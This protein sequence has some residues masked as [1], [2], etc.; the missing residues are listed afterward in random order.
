MV[1]KALNLVFS[2]RFVFLGLAILMS[3]LGVVTGPKL[4]LQLSISK[5]LPEDRQSVVEMN[6]VAS[7]VGGVGFLVMIIGPTEAP[8]QY[9]PQLAEKMQ[10]SEHVSYS[11]YNTEKHLLKDK[12]LYLL[13]K[14]DFK[15]L[16]RSVRDLF[17]NANIGLGLTS[18]EE[19]EKRAKDF[20]A[21]IDDK[22]QSKPFF[23]SKDGRYAMV[24]VKPKF[25]SEDLDR[26]K[27]LVNHANSVAHEVLKGKV[28]YH[29]A[30]R[31]ADKVRDTRQIQNDIA[32]T[33][34][35]SLVGLSI[36]L[37]WGLGSF[38]ATLVTLGGVLVSLGWTMGIAKYAVGQI[39]I[40]TGFLLAIL[41]G[42]GVEYGIH[43]IRR[44]EQE[45][46]SG[47]DHLTSL[48]KTYFQMG[49]ALFSAAI[50]S[51]CAF[52]ILSLS[53]FRGFSE[54]GIIAGLGVLGIYFSYILCFPALG[55]MLR[56]KP[57][58]GQSRKIFGVY[59]F[60]KKWAKPILIVSCILFFCAPLAEFEYDF[61]RMHRL[62]KKSKEM[63]D[64]SDELFGKSLTPA[65]LLASDRQQA[66]QLR[67]WLIKEEQKE[68]IQNAVSIENVTPSDMKSRYRQIK[69]LNKRIDDISDE[70][71]KEK[72]DLSAKEVRKWLQEKPYKLSDLP[73]PF[74]STFGVSEKI[75]YT[76]PVENLNQA[77]PLRRFTGKLKEARQEFPGTQ[78]G[79]DATV[80]VEIIEHIID[81]G[82]IVLLL[83]L[84]GAFFVF[85]LDF[86][87][88]TGALVLELQ[89][90]AGI[91]LLC[92]LMAIFG[93]RFSILNVAM[94]PA[95]LAAGVDMGVHVRH[96]E[97]EGYSPLQ[98]AKYVAQAVQLSML[99]TMMGF[100][101]VLFA[102]AGILRGIALIS[103]LGQIS[104][105]LIC[106]VIVP[107]L[108][109]TFGQKISHFFFKKNRKTKV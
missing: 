59:P 23:L 62:S 74:P 48:K 4:P 89:L 101:A 20:F 64:L 88:V 18:K 97:L 86:K 35:I 63:N 82:K 34:L 77:D 93:E 14:S 84:T 70:K 10:T 46:I 2:H 27:R 29:L 100:G 25:N 85:W 66:N 60:S 1:R 40:L 6:N 99:T 71:I 37:L 90:I 98:A 52:L 39:N 65:A 57:R 33:G 5:L 102:E 12:A 76:Y 80:F 36:I 24:L 108:K 42:L 26:S 49:R 9:L 44:Y 19:K 56:G 95:V 50:T 79:S 43:L 107:V 92:G 78:I 21:T 87:T 83:F 11:F 51:S 72:T 47:F 17:A 75:V 32:K 94:V 81:D 45:R 22:T 15:K 68:I 53:D 58:F 96:R 30:G 67:K 13:S 73:E 8:E 109:E 104:M 105:Y 91:I 103:I 28:G 106:M 54:L 7:Y 69:K 55:W 16:R 31:F 3:V 38:R 61:E 41:G